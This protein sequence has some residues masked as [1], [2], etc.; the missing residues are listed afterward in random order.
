MVHTIRRGLIAAALIA[1]GAIG[2]AAPAAADPGLGSL[3]GSSGG[4]GSASLFAGSGDI[5]RLVDH[6][7]YVVKK[8]GVDH[9]A[10][11]T[12]A[13]H[14]SRYA[15]AENAKIKPRGRRRAP[16]ASLWPEGA[17]G[18]KWPRAR[19]LAWTNWP[20]FTV[21]MVQR[22]YTDDQIRKILGA[23]ILRVCKDVLAR[24]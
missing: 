8:F 2:L 3:F 15:A 10:I 6:I 13:A 11:G 7:D 22:G 18:G 1:G 17:L 9:V 24:P 21:A 19:T 16:F 12:D 5:A 20:L 14:E 23:N 4:N